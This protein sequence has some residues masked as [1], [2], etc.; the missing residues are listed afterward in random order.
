MKIEVNYWG[1]HPDE[2]NDDCWSG[3]DFDNLDDALAAY[4]KPVLHAYCQRSTAFIEITGPEIREVR[5][6]PNYRPQPVDDDW[7]REAQMQSAMAHGCDG[8]N[9]YV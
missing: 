1:S 8:W 6:N 2:C 7:R 5:P 4:N 9:D 3:E